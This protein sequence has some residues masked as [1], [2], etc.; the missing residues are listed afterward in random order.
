[1]SVMS[2]QAKEISSEIRSPVWIVGASI[3]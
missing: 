3:V 2:W 1:V